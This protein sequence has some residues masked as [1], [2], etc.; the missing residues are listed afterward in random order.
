MLNVRS[1]T[2]NWLPVFIWMVVIFSAS[3]DTQS[4]YHSSRIIEP[5]LRWLFPHIQ[6]NQIWPVVLIARKCAHLAEYAIFAVLIWR[7]VRSLSVPNTGWSWRVARNAWF[8]VVVY[9]MTDEW[10]QRFVPTRQSSPWDVV[11]DSTGGAVGLLLLY[12]FGR[13]RKWWPVR[14]PAP[15][16]SQPR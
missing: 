6:P 10:H 3:A 5:L 14:P 15:A 13:W 9:A 11:I 1:T 12:A 2:R 16:R 4:S 8:C 7:G